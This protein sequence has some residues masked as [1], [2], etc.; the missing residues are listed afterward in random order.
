MTFQDN[1]TFDNHI[2]K[3]TSTANSRLG[4]IRNTFHF[5]DRGGF[6]ISYGSMVFQYGP[7][8]LENMIR[9]HPTEGYKI[10]EWRI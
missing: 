3:I 2:S 4:I 9:T 8:I 5:I 10:N 1:L 6:V 7:L